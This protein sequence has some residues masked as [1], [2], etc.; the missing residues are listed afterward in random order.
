MEANKVITELENI[1]LDINLMND[2]HHKELERIEVKVIELRRKIEE[3]I[4]K[5]LEDENKREFALKHYAD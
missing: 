4:E 2:K 3:S 1:Q 5:M